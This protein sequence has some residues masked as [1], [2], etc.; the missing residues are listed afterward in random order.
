[1]PVNATFGGYTWSR[2]E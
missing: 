1:M 2:K